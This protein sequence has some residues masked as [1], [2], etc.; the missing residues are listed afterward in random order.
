VQ[1]I[2]K[3]PKIMNVP[4]ISLSIDKIYLYLH[5]AITLIRL[6]DN[7][8]NNANRENSIYKYYKIQSASRLHIL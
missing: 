6:N 4:V 8:E 2:L 3:L 1:N 5:I 7:Y